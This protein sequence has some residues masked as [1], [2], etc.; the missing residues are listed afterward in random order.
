MPGS[1]HRIWLLRAFGARIGAGVR[2]KP[3]LRVK[4]PWRL[5]VGARSWIG[6]G[7]WI[8]NLAPVEI[9]ADCCISQGAYLCTGG[10][11]WSKQGFDL[12][13][14]PITISDAVWIGAKAIVGPGV[15]A[16][17]GAVLALGSRA[18]KDLEPWTIHDGFPCAPL[19]P[20]IVASDETRDSASV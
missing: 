7:V 16:G 17:P 18:T 11:D 6:E 1:W 8:D 15:T 19:K 13:V 20:R 10:H 12:L 3:R 5:Q 2:A 4:F 9:G 14:Q